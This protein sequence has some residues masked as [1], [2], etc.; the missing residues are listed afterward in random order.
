MDDKLLQHGAFSWFELTTS[1]TEAAKE[2]YTG[3][4]GWE[5]REM[6][7]QD[8]TYTVIRVGGE[9]VAG[10]MGPPPGAENMPPQWS[11]YIT[12]DDVDATAEKAKELGGKVLVEPRDIPEVGRFCVIRDPQGA[13]FSLMTYKS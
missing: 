5:L 11:N 7:M 10:I 1:D 4:L 8:M 2:F 9:D 3:L 13:W 12:V 6:P